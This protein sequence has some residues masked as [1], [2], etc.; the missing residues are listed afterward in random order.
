MYTNNVSLDYVLFNTAIYKLMIRW[1]LRNFKTITVHFK[2]FKS[3]TYILKCKI[4]TFASVML[5]PLRAQ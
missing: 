1:E 5:N 4:Y 2:F 3:Y